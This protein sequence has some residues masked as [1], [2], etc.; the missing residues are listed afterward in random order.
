MSYIAGPSVA[1]L[2]RHLNEAR[3]SD[4]IPYE[5][6]LGQFVSTDE[7]QARWSNLASWYNQ[8]GHF[9]VG[10]G[11]F[12]LERAYPVERSSTSSEIPT[13]PTRPTSGPSLLSP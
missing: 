9:W 8:K 2:A 7:A 12:Y 10:T 6:T 3:Q 1:T 5:P 11:P 4:Y 13:S